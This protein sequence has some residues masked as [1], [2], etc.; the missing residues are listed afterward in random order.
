M[1]TLFPPLGVGLSIYASLTK[2]APYP[3]FR[4]QGIGP[5][6]CS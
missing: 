2:V 1:D 5:P 6:L 3:R 4:A